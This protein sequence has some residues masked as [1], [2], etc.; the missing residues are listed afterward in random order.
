MKSEKLKVK[1]FGVLRG[2]VGL[3][4]GGEG[5]LFTH[6]FQCVPRPPVRAFQ[7]SARNFDK[8]LVRKGVVVLFP[9]WICCSVL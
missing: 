2:R 8:T 7:C 4:H 5:G 6:N 9:V 1:W 3:S